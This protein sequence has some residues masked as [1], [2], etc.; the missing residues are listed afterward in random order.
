MTHENPPKPRDPLMQPDEAKLMR[1][2]FRRARMSLPPFRMKD[3][4]PWS[5]GALRLFPVLDAR[6]CEI[7]E[8]WVWWRKGVPYLG[9]SRFIGSFERQLRYDEC[10]HLCVAAEDGDWATIDAFDPQALPWYCRACGY[11]YGEEDWT[12]VSRGSIGGG[13]LGG[14]CPGGHERVVAG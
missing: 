11:N 14:I 10:G 8:L 12:I 2:K 3:D 6:G 7:A 9:R 4:P 13:I 5:P 1:D